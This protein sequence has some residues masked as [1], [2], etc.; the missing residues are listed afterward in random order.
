MR[1]IIGIP[2]IDRNDK[3]SKLDIF[4]DNSRTAIIIKI[5]EIVVDKLGVDEEKVTLDAKFIDDLGA[6]SL[7]TVEL[8]MQFEDDFNIEIPDEDA[9]KILSV[10]QAEAYINIHYQSTAPKFVG[11]LY[12]LAVVV[13]DTEL[14]GQRTQPILGATVVGKV[15]DCAVRL[16][17]LGFELDAPIAGQLPDVNTLAPLSSLGNAPVERAHLHPHF[18]P[19]VLGVGERVGGA[20]PSEQPVEFGGGELGVADNDRAVRERAARPKLDGVG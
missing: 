1:H 7:D 6:D 9:E 4:V 14:N 8:I 18:E 12:C 17:E 3:I 11:A 16:G 10:G 20:L 13:G 15:V 5:K 2:I 19:A